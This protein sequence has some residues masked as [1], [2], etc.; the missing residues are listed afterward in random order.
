MKGSG[1]ELSFELMV[2]SSP[3][4]ETQLSAGGMAEG[5]ARVIVQRKKEVVALGKKC[6]RIFS[7][8]SPFDAKSAAP[9]WQ[10]P[11]P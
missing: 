4:F 9:S 7:A 8:E 10:R 2:V 3:L 5:A 1:C 6:L 11:M